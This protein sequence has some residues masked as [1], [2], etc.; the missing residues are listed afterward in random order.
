MWYLIP[1][2]KTYIRFIYNQKFYSK[3]SIFNSCRLRVHAETGNLVGM[4]VYSFW[5]LN[6]DYWS[7]EYMYDISRIAKKLPG[8]IPNQVNSQ[9]VYFL[10]VKQFAEKKIYQH[11]YMCVPHNTLPA[12][13]PLWDFAAI[14]FMAYTIPCYCLAYSP[15]P[16]QSPT[17]CNVTIKSCLAASII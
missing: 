3:L 7:R 9:N 6:G 5:A 14:A 1:L 12:M 11:V 2:K 8:S 15:V 17:M 4:V 13:S 16:G 10:W